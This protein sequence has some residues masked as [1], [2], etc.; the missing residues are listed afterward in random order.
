[1]IE[2]QVF[3]DSKPIAV[4]V[5]VFVVDG[6]AVMTF[7]AKVSFIHFIYGATFV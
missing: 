6:G 7:S 4:L 2:T 3:L 5:V 1:M